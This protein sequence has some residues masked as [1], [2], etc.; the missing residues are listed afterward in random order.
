MGWKGSR[1]ITVK[2]ASSTGSPA[3]H[4]VTP[5]CSLETQDQRRAPLSPPRPG[6]LGLLSSATHSV[7]QAKGSASA[8]GPCC[9]AEPRVQ[10]RC[11]SQPPPRSGP[12]PFPLD[13]SHH[14]LVG[15]LPSTQRPDGCLWNAT[16]ATPLLHPNILQGTNG[17]QTCMRQSGKL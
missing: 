12:P 2:D 6:T 17:N 13:H 7:S 16:W 9:L 15:L 11:S 3:T 10:D 14:L 5:L 8:S 1:Q 4:W